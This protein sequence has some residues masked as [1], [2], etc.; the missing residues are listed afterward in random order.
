M[1]YGTF[2]HTCPENQ[3]REHLGGQHLH[4]PSSM[5]LSYLKPSGC[6]RG[7]AKDV[8]TMRDETRTLQ[9]H[10][11]SWTYLQVSW[12]RNTTKSSIFNILIGFSIINHPYGDTPMEIPTWS[13]ISAA[14]ISHCWAETPKMCSMSAAW[15]GPQFRHPEARGSA[16]FDHTLTFNCFWEEALGMIPMSCSSFVEWT[17]CTKGLPSPKPFPFHFPSAF[18]KQTLKSNCV[19]LPILNE[20][21][22][23]Q[24]KYLD[25]KV[26]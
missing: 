23:S 8:T 16:A 11:E 9:E 4:V 20:R 25:P 24:P 14:V 19:H 26:S 13:T 1:I 21:A 22:F 3:F 6:S 10:L 7:S 17:K 18:W 12:N 5:L 15:G 2:L